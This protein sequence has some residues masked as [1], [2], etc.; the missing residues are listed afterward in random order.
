MVG[1]EEVALAGQNDVLWLRRGT[2]GCIE[3]R[4]SRLPDARP[5]F[6]VHRHRHDNTLI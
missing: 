1:C 5:E 3:A 2:D 6:A 4:G